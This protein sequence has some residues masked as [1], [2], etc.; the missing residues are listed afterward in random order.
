M[1]QLSQNIKNLKLDKRLYTLN[2][3]MGEIDPQQHQSYLQSL[4]DLSA[5]SK[6]LYDMS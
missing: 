3:K 4:E 6:K 2:V 5:K 1:S